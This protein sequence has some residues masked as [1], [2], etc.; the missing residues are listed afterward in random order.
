MDS[1]AFHF[2]FGLGFSEGLHERR[3][4]NRSQFYVD[5]PSGPFYGF[6]RPGAKPSQA[7]IQNWWRQ[8][9][10]GGANVHYDGIKAFSE[11]DFTEDLKIIDVPALVMRGPRLKPRAP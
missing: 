3:A 2:C 1:F 7:I 10:T 5:L 6:N 4:A 8:G 9:M 11:T